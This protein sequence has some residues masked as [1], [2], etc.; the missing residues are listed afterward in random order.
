L[1]LAD[2]LAEPPVQM[3]GPRCSIYLLLLQLDADETA[4]LNTALADERFTSVAIADA[5]QAEGYAVKESPLRRH[6]LGRCACGD[7]L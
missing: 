6:R 4:A 3:K 5:L 1:S 2:R 7:A